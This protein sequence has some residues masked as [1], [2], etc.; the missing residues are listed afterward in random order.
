MEIVDMLLLL[1]IATPQSEAIKLI[2]VIAMPMVLGD[3]IGI[4]IFAFMLSNL[5][6]EK[7]LE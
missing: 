4:A 5:K 1:L 2:N 7:Q 3:T 6:K